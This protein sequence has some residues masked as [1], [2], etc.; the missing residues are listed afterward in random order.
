MIKLQG[1]TPAQVEICDAIWEFDTQEEVLNW[2]DNLPDSMVFDAYCMLQL[3]TAEC[4][5]QV[6]DLDLT[7]ARAVINRIQQL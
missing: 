1:L 2:F 7:A 3:I 4:L 5:D 6:D